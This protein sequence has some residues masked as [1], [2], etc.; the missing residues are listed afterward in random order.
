MEGF[1]K[2]SFPGRFF[3]QN[4]A[5]VVRS[6]PGAINKRRSTLGSD[7]VKVGIGKV[8]AGTKNFT[9]S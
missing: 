8:D 2:L 7:S 3:V 5:A 9:R 6:S 4:I 1:P